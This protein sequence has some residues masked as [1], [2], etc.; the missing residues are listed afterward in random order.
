VLT[1]LGMMVIEDDLAGVNLALAADPGLASVRRGNTNACLLAFARSAAMVDVLVVAGLD[2]NDRDTA[3]ITP[4]HRAAQGANF[5]MAKRLLDLGAD[6]LAVDG[7]SQTAMHWLSLEHHNFIV[8]KSDIVVTA[9]L[10][11]EAGTPTGSFLGTSVDSPVNMNAR[12]GR[13]DVVEL[14]IRSGADPTARDGQGMNALHCAERHPELRR[15][16]IDWAEANG[17][18]WTT[19]ISETEMWSGS[20]NRVRLHPDGRHAITTKQPGAIATWQLGP[21]STPRKEAR[22]DGSRIVDAAFLPD[23]TSFVCA[24]KGGPIEIRSWDEPQTLLRKIPCP[25]LSGAVAVAPSGR[26]VAVRAQLEEV[27]IIAIEDGRL[28]SI[29][30]GGE[31]T[32]SMAWSHDGKHL[33]IA[34]SYQGGSRVGVAFIDSDGIVGPEMDIEVTDDDRRGTPDCE[35]VCGVRFAPDDTSLI[36]WLTTRSDFRRASLGWR[37]NLVC[38]TLTG[39]LRWLTPIDGHLTG[40]KVS[41]PAAGYG[42]GFHTEPAFSAD[43][44]LVAVGVDG[45]FFEIDATTGTLV[46]H[47]TVSGHVYSTAY[48]QDLD[49]WVLAT[50][51]GVQLHHRNT[52]SN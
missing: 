25:D 34:A 5:G 28:L 3:G 21:G 19:P 22:T 31:Y 44:R 23:G 7:R 11:I 43:G 38:S 13:L 14:L 46:N 20:H 26:L 47:R 18:T 35:E 42:M 16:L 48:S 12:Y 41:L 2:V 8:D 51:N 37:G 52:G 49:S 33:A 45:H 27:H 40:G 30:E 4:L 15:W 29:I 6:P 24:L 32:E 10:L 50:S 36:F 1:E 39:E 9:S 17:R